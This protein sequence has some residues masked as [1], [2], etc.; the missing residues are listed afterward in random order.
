MFAAFYA[1]LLRC[2]FTANLEL[3]LFVLCSCLPPF[4]PSVHT[5]S[6]DFITLDDVSG[7]LFFSGLTGVIWLDLDLQI[8]D[9]R[10]F[11]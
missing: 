4:P 1:F 3:F 9:F 10:G 7:S 2:G 8:W 5:F 6:F 11:Q